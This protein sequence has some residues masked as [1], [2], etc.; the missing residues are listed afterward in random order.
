MNGISILLPE[1]FDERE[2]AAKNPVYGALS[3][4]IEKQE[5]V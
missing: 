3:K 2:S 4:A 1:F 5:G